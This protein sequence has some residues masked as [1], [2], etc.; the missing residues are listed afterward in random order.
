MVPLVFILIVSLVL[1]LLVWWVL[2]TL[3]IDGTYDKEAGSFFFETAPELYTYGYMPDIRS[4]IPFENN[5][6]RLNRVNSKRLLA[7]WMIDDDKADEFNKAGSIDGELVLRICQTGSVYKDVPAESLKDSYHFEFKPE[8]AYYAVL[9]M[10][11]DDSFF[12]WLY[13]NTVLT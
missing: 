11:K 7:Y 6:L 8:T 2:S 13:S 12:P 4:Y 1:F 9:G 5:C 10:K 3:R